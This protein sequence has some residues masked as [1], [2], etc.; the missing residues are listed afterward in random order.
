MVPKVR[1]LMSF[2]LQLRA[3]VRPSLSARTSTSTAR[4]TLRYTKPR[5][6]R[7]LNGG[8]N[9]PAEYVVEFV[10]GYRQREELAERFLPGGLGDPGYKCIRAYVTVDDEMYGRYPGQIPTLVTDAQVL[11]GTLILANGQ[12]DIVFEVGPASISVILR[13]ACRPSVCTASCSTKRSQ[14]RMCTRRKTA[15]PT[16]TRSLV[17]P[18]MVV[19]GATL[20]LRKR[21]PL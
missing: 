6:G 12:L 2:Q 17:T 1:R 20:W 14:R 21:R 3:C 16:T 7:V 5:F 9:A 13:A 11:P 10:H 4:H 8:A 18:A 19:M 15:T